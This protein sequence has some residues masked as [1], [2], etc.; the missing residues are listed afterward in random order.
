MEVQEQEQTELDVRT[1]TEKRVDE[2][3]VKNYQDT[4]VGEPFLLPLEEKE[5]AQLMD[6]VVVLT[7]DLK[8]KEKEFGKVKLGFKNA[9]EGLKQ[10]IQ[11]KVYKCERG[12]EKS[13]QCTKRVN[14][15]TRRTTF[16]SLE[17]GTV[18]KEREMFETEK[19]LTLSP[20]VADLVQT[21]V[22]DESL[23]GMSDAVQNKEPLD[24]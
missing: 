6:Q 15:D 8:E 18:L 9:I 7:I 20:D 10:D 14:F 3:R 13:V 1:E 4:V 12:T 19:Q 11:S 16:L 21:S 24:F 2:L 22:T 17:D 23:E 5:K